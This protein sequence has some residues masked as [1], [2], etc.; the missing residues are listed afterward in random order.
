MKKSMIKLCAKLSLWLLV[1]A[2]TKP[3]AAEHSFDLY[4]ADR[5]AKG[6]DST[7]VIFANW[8]NE[9]EGLC[10]YLDD[11]DNVIVS[12]NILTK[13]NVLSA[14]PAVHYEYSFDNAPP[15]VSPALQTSDLS[16][17]VWLGENI[18]VATFL[19]KLPFGSVCLEPTQS[20]PLD[21]AFK[22]VTPAT[23]GAY[24]AYPIAGYIG[25]LFPDFVHPDYA[26]QSGIDMGQKQICCR[27]PPSPGAELRRGQTTTLQTELHVLPNPFEDHLQIRGTLARGE[28]L[29]IELYDLTGR[30][31]LQEQQNTRP[32]VDY[33]LATDDLPPGIYFIRI[34]GG[35]PTKVVK[36]Q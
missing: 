5:M 28:A 12:I 27:T 7:R 15:N 20:I 33:T 19:H 2:L 34:N 4:P 30:V 9:Y 11:D 24:D 22:L 6:D 14:Y 1:L 25:T 13:T 35:E 26:A 32:Y 16:P 31:W 17:T 10:V 3:L 21:Y 36:T 23:G 8:N 18:Y 29:R